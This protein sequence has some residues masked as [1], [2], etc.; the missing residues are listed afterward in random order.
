MS[1]TISID[2]ALG[3]HK[4]RVPYMN[5]PRNA[6]CV[7]VLNIYCDTYDQSISTL[8]KQ[9]FSDAIVTISFPHLYK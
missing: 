8:S 3:S 2:I 7:K 1:K 5:Y 4:L 6:E 9:L